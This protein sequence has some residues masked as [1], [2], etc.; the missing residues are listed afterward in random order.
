M[1]TNTNNNLN[2]VELNINKKPLSKNLLS[3]TSL[4]SL[5]TKTTMPSFTNNKIYSGLTSSTPKTLKF[6]TTEFRTL[7]KKNVNTN[8]K[9]INNNLSLKKSQITNIQLFDFRKNNYKRD[10]HITYK[11]P[12]FT[13]GY[14]KN[15]VIS[16]ELESIKL[17][18]FK[19]NKSH[20]RIFPS[21]DNSF[22]SYNSKLCQKLKVNNIFNVYK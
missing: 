8:F 9:N 19:H 20:D 6:N 16:P 18:T 22:T 2:K 17:K 21:S 10:Y 13:K 14:T 12:Y 11:N 3:I 5:R 1:S 7:N 15:Y 4:K